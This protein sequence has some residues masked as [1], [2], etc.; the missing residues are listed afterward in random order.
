TATSTAIATATPGTTP[1]TTAT[2][3]GAATPT[4]SAQFTPTATSIAATPTATATPGGPGVPLKVVPP[5]GST[6][7]FGKIKVGKSRTKKVTLINTSKTATITF[8]SSQESLNPP[9]GDFEFSPATTCAGTLPPKHKCSIF[10]RF[11]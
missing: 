6:L 1:T 2:V 7:N 9:T 5:P 10:V 11:T 8:G 3:T 4:A